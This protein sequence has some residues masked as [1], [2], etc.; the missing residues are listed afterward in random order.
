[1]TEDCLRH[2][3]A[4]AFEYAY[5]HNDWVHPLEEALAGVTAA[6]ALRRYAPDS[7]GIWDIVLHTAVWNENIVERV[8]SGEKSHPPEGAWPPPPSLADEAAWE[9]DKQRLRDSLEAVRA[10]VADG[11]M[12]AIEA[13]PYGLPDLLCRYIHVGYH[14]GQITKLREVVAPR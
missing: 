11:P 5:L 13:S 4:L 10:M 6:E 14:I 3:L 1:M 7:M 8:R 9:R 2:G 12:S